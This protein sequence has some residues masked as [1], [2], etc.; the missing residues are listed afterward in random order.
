MNVAMNK[1]YKYTSLLKRVDANSF[2]DDDNFLLW[3]Y[4]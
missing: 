4:F 1:F 3:N 2:D